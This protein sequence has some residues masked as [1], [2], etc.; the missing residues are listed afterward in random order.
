MAA[1]NGGRS[2]REGVEAVSGPRLKANAA[3]W[4]I[5]GRARRL[6]DVPSEAEE[7]DAAEPTLATGEDDP[8]GARRCL[9]RGSA[10]LSRC[11]GLALVVWT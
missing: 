11:G 6:E 2:R 5:C 4:L 10:V 9:A 8:S 7:R 1:L 3:E